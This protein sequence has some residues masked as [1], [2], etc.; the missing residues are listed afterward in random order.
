MHEDDGTFGALALRE[1]D[2]L[3]V[4]RDVLL[5]PRCLI[6]PV[7]P[8]ARVSRNPALGYARCSRA[9]EAAPRLES[10]Q[11][12]E[13][14]LRFI[15]MAPGEPEGTKSLSWVVAA[16]MAEVLTHDPVSAMQVGLAGWSGCD[17]R[18]KSSPGPRQMVDRLLRQPE[19]AKHRH[20][21]HE[22][23][24]GGGDRGGVRAGGR[25]RFGRRALRWHER[26]VRVR[27]RSARRE[28]RR[29]GQ[30]SREQR[31]RERRS[32]EQRPRERRSREQRPRERRS[33]ERRA[34]ERRSREQRSRKRRSR[35]R[36]ARCGAV[37]AA[38]VTFGGRCR[39]G[40]AAWRHSVRVGGCGGGAYRAAGRVRCATRRWPGDGCLLPGPAGAA[41]NDARWGKGLGDQRHRAS[42]RVAIGGARAGGRG[43]RGADWVVSD[44]GR[45]LVTGDAG[46]TWAAQP[47]PSPVVAAASAGGWL[48]A[49]SCPP[50]N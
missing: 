20:E 31:P 13:R 30:R 7:W 49:L 5:R 12:P 40:V 43:G 17:L 48:W 19:P 15:R 14:R 1:C 28:R 35:K 22:S 8:G 47:V 4:D 34:R 37:Q 46:A 23:A 32:R 44:T 36:R 26:R 29:D 18:G 16:V 2:P 45:L 9:A 25:M 50:V 10:L 3:A 21:G 41:G 33:R 6:P 38:G 39:S 24:A 27:L 42:R 11:R